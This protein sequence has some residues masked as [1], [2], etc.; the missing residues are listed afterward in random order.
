MLIE[1][2]NLKEKIRKVQERGEG[3][4]KA[5][6]ELKWSG[7][8]TLKDKEWSIKEGLVLKKD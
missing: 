2:E 8:K 4:V 1:I 5:V 3:V 7:M 6:E